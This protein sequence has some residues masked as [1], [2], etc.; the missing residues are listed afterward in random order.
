PIYL[1]V[2]A[3]R[4]APVVVDGSVVVRPQLVLVATGDHRIV[5]GAQAGRITTVLRELL[6][7]P[8]RLDT[9]WQPSPS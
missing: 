7:E 3:V 5:D 6:A 1:A 2:G 8:A 4:D 9:P